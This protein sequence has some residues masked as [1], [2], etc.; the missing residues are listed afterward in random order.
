MTA[1][2]PPVAG[3]PL[4]TAIAFVGAPIAIAVALLSGALA[5][6][7]VAGATE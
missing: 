7:L 5:L 6:V 1:I 3:V 2:L 4:D